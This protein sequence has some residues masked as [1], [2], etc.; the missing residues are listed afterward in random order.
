MLGA[1]VD[2]ASVFVASTVLM[3]LAGLT[4]GFLAYESFKVRNSPAK[5]GQA[6]AKLL[7]LTACISYP[8]LHCYILLSDT[9]SLQESRYATHLACDNNTLRKS[10]NS[11]ESSE[12]RCS[13]AAGFDKWTLGVWLAEVWKRGTVGLYLGHNINELYSVFIYSNLMAQIAPMAVLASLSAMA[14]VGYTYYH[15]KMNIQPPPNVY[16]KGDQACWKL[17][18]GEEECVCI[19]EEPEKKGPQV[20]PTGPS[21]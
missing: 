14:I 12:N 13:E 11:H 7:V 21:K 8:C 3:C 9:V 15:T 4:T 1:L 5:L 19:H 20:D 18:G 2:T 6:L 10:W 17:P 16:R